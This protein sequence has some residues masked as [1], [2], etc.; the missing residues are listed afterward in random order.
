MSS[1][2]FVVFCLIKIVFCVVCRD[3]IKEGSKEVGG[4]GREGKSLPEKDP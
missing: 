4:K 1:L 2:L 3:V